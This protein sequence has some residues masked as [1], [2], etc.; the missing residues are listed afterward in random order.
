MNV[1]GA[2]ERE[3]RAAV[4]AWPRADLPALLEA[5]EAVVVCCATVTGGPEA[6][7]ALVREILGA[8][9][10]RAPGGKPYIAA[11]ASERGTARGAL[12]FNISHSGNALL[13]A[14]SR[15]AEVGVDVER[16]RAVPEWRAIAKRMFDA[17]TTRLLHAELERG[18]DESDAF[19]RCW[20]RHEA[21]VKATGEGLFPRETRDAANAYQSGR[22]AL[23]VIDLPDLPLPA[24]A[25][26]YRGALAL[27]Q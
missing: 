1:A 24:G 4:V 3:L 11:S 10:T 16:V 8:E 6:A 21:S 5:N 19:I 27:L 20:C 9:R 14:L 18:A 7:D 15:S 25:G 23:R 26:R 2:T 17:A 22:A 13:V 12:N